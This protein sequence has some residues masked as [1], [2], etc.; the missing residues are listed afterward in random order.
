MTSIVFLGD[1]PTELGEKVFARTSEIYYYPERSG[2]TTPEW[3]GYP[4]K[5]MV[6]GID[7]TGTDLS[8]GIVSYTLINSEAEDR[9]V[10]MAAYDEDGKMLKIQQVILKPNGVIKSEWEVPKNC[11][12]KLF[13]TDGSSVP[14][15]DDRSIE[16]T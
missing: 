7:T 2:W 10:L 13:M 6:T 8:E 16:L 1:V 14:V 9:I 12:V 4:T 5:P 3:N 15:M 11:T